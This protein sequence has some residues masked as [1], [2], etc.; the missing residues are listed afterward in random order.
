MN[1]IIDD[2]G[3]C[4]ISKDGNLVASIQ[5]FPN[6]TAAYWFEKGTKAISAKNKETALILIYDKLGF[7]EC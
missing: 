1:I 6:G 4:R 7:S 2:L 3:I 5:N